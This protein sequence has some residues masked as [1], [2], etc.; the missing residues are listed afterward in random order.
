MNTNKSDQVAR[1][2]YSPQ[3]KDHAVERA[4]KDGIPQVAKDLGIKEIH[5]VLLAIST[6]ARWRFH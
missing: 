5:V 6:E 2:K 4:I 3:F 1:K